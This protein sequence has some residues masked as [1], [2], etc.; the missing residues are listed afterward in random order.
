MIEISN[1]KKNYNDLEVLRGVS[2]DIKEGEVLSIIGPSGTG[3][4]T[5]LRCI[6][7]IEAPDNGTISFH[8][9][10][11][12]N[13]SE[14]SKDKVYQLRSYSTMVFQNYFLFN[15]MT[16]L[17]NITMNLILVQKK[18]K[19]EAVEIGEDL[20][21]K[22]GLL[23]KKNEYPSRL[24]GGQKQRVGIARAMAVKPK[25]MLFDEP[26]SSLDPELVSEVLDVIKKLAE[27]KQTMIIVTHEMDF[28]KS[29]SDRVAFMDE[30]IIKELDTPF[31]IF[32]NPK[33][34]RL[35]TFLKK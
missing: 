27:E 13:L 1:I 24:S 31:N 23:D 33:D 19:R 22:V 30:G 7:Y 2:L 12:F 8:D 6:N 26:T 25:L 32:N 21:L 17:E 10:E 28:A 3:K 34:K 18:S 16:A 11:F 4:S 14:I 20:L 5:F 15:N 35:K 9:G 29:V